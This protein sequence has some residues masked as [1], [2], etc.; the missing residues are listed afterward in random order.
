MKIHQ[1]NSIIR[2]LGFL[3]SI[4]GFIPIAIIG[5]KSLIDFKNLNSFQIL[6]YIGIGSIFCFIGWCCYHSDYIK[7]NHNDIENNETKF[8]GFN[9]TVIPKEE[10]SHITLIDA[11]I[12]GPH[13]VTP[14]KKLVFHLN[15]GE[16]I[17]I[18]EAHTEK[19]HLKLADKIKAHWDITSKQKLN[20]N[21]DKQNI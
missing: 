1:T 12:Q 5:Y 9:K 8:W 19:Y 13:G 14:G 11:N 10:I 6:L 7:I 4:I 17:S 15:N 20:I 18:K 16:Q 3:F 21:Y 2:I